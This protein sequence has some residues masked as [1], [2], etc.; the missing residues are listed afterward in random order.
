MNVAVLSLFALV[1]FIDCYFWLYVLR[2]FLMCECVC[3]MYLRLCRASMRVSVRVHGVCV[4]VYV[5]VVN[6]CLCDESVR[7]WFVA[8]ARC[9]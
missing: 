1:C 4:S 8:R 5:C 3:L 7:A 6:A 9:V 2:L